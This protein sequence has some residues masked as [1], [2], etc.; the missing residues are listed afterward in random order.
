MGHYA[1]SIGSYRRQLGQKTCHGHQTVNNIPQY[2]CLELILCRRFN[3]ILQYFILLVG[4]E[5]GNTLRDAETR[6]VML[7]RAE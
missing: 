7:K 2:F 6:C 3:I 4:Q 5:K 1:V